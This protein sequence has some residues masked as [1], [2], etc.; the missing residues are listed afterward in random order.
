V[1]GAYPVVA[2]TGSLAAAERSAELAS[3]LDDCEVF[4]QRGEGFGDRLANAHADVAARF[5]GLPVLQI[6]MDT[7]QLMPSML[8]GALVRLLESD[9]A[10]GPAL[11][12]GWWGLGLRDPLAA[13]VL[14]DVPMS[15]ADTGQ[16]TLFALRDLG[17]RVCRLP[18]LSDVDTLAD[19]GRVAALA[20]SSR[21]AQAFAEASR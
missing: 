2:M 3:A 11:D 14:R 19:A 8:T 9:A 4:E 16:R 17:L 15:R 6:G 20:P 1:P 21:F 13:G 12:G 18:S 10:L 5:P 7:P